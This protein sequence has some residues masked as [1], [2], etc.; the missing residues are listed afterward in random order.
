M[1]KFAIAIVVAGLS[2]CQSVPQS[3]AHL[4]V[5][6]QFSPSSRCSPVNPQITLTGVPTGT[7][8]YAVHMTDLDKPDY[9]HG[10]G[11]IIASG[12]VIPSGALKVYKGPCPPAGP[13]RYEISVKALDASGEIVGFGKSSQRFP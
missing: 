5:N 4:G 1:K 13:H 2:G 9:N 10:G 8:K 6:F 7:A 3:A 12:N 11:T